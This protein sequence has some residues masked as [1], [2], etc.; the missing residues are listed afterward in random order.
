MILN[1]LTVVDMTIENPLNEREIAN[2]AALVLQKRFI[3]AARNGT[4][5]YVEND[6]LVSKTPNGKP[7]LIKQLSG[8]N[9][10]LARQFN[11][12]RTFKIRKR[13]IEATA[14]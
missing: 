3:E 2:A 7:V 5:L 13:N 11:G 10:D 12:R 6:A 14:E 1:Q 9:P 4:V 8:R